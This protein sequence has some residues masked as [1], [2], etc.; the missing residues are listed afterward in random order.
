MGAPLSGEGA[1]YLF[2]PLPAGA[3]LLNDSQ[4]AAMEQ[5]LFVAESPVSRRYM[6]AQYY[7]RV[8]TQQ[9]GV[10]NFEVWSD[11]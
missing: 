10:A 4:L 9:K 2:E 6:N 3:T 8:A 1:S 7:Q 5:R 11:L